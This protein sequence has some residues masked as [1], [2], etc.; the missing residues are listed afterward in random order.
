MRTIYLILTF[1]CCIIAKAETFPYRSIASFNISPASESYCMMLDS[2]GM[3]WVGTNSGLKSYDGYTVKS[4]KSNALSPGILPNNDIRSIAEDH[5][6]NLWVGTRN[7]LVKIN[8]KT[9]IFKT[10][11]L[12]TENQRIIYHL[13]VAK[14]GT[15]WIGTDG[16]LTYFNPK[17][18][19]FYTYTSRN[20]WRID[21][22][23]KKQRLNSFSVKCVAEDKN[24]DLLVGT[25]SSGLMRLKR[26][27]N[28]FRSYPKLNDTNS[29]YS[30]FFDRNHRLWVG[31]WGYGV[32]CISNPGNLRNPQ[33]HQYPYAT[34][35][36]DIFYKFVEDPTT[37]TLWAC[38]RE[39]ICYLDEKQPQANW[40][41]Y[42]QIGNN[43]LIYCN[44][45]S[46]DG[47]GN[48]WLCTQ[49]DGVLQITTTP[50]LF[51]QWKL[52][53]LQN[54]PT[55]NYVNAIL[56]TDGA[57]FWL[58]L[59]PYGVALYN[60]YTGATYYN[61]EIPGFSSLH[62]NTL[63]TSITSIAQRSNG[64]IWFAIN[65]YGVV[66]KPRGGEMPSS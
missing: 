61:R 30:L 23:G 36:F 13:F 11:F 9:G 1:V 57:W 17:N 7:G 50:S 31:T 2:E 42:T 5:E 51:R 29:A 24:G 16:G 25:W 38:T 20:A 56:T 64:E 41:K 45:I 22:N 62:D 65:N 58:G 3:M 19:S 40:Q 46:T 4:Y 66:V 34:N 54:A 43:R 32:L 53:N 14:D 63:T 44:D 18:E 26:G 52:G 27:S 15:L 10:Y 21:E 49:N 6:Q 48:I 59:N 39:G 8:R 33:Y 12:P 60:R 35:N 28:V 37:N 55:I 47:A